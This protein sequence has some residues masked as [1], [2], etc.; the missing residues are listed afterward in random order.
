MQPTFAQIVRV[1]VQLGFT[2]FGGGRSAYY[3]EALVAR[4][5][6]IKTQ[7]FL[8][9]LTL[10]QILPGPNVT[11]LAVAVGRRLAGFAGAASSFVA[12]ILPGAVALLVLT[13]FYFH[14]T[15]T[16]GAQSAIRGG[17]AAVVGVV[18][19]TTVKMGSVFRGW[20]VFAIAGSAFVAVGPLRLN[21]I[22][23][24]LVAGA[25]SLWLQRPRS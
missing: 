19:V 25:V 21:T 16:S 23:T 4:R 2:S 3:Y 15:I 24:V 14:G 9:D 17:A 11:N 22:A 20:R 8:Q 1:F 13:T 6:W 10:S 5:R 18:V 12:V 7:D